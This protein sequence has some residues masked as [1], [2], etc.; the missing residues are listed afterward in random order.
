L[1][2]FTFSETTET[3][4]AEEAEERE[5]LT[6]TIVFQ[7]PQEEEPLNCSLSYVSGDSHYAHALF[8]QSNLSLFE[9]VSYLVA[10]PNFTLSG[11]EVDDPSTPYI[12][13]LTGTAFNHTL[14]LTASE[15]L[16]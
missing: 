14:T 16:L 7:V 10:R 9:P 15:P 11:L 1:A 13:N 6:A 2:T 12:F 5:E 8:L 3:E 4:E